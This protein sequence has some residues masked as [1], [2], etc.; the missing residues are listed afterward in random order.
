[1]KF[2]HIWIVWASLVKDL[3][4]LRLELVNSLISFKSCFLIDIFIHFVI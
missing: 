4:F 3:S 1:M 2:S